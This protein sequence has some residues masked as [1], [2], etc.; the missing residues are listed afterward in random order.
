MTLRILACQIDIPA[1]TTAEERDAHLARVV[2]RVDAMLRAAPAD[3]VVLPELSSIDYSRAAFDRLEVLA[4]PLDGPSFDCWS[5]V[6]KAHGCTAVY[7][8]P[9][10]EGE[11]TYVTM[12][13]VGPDGRLVGHYDKIHLAQYGMSSEK[14][15]FTRGEGTFFFEVGGFRI[16]PI[17]CYDIRIPELSRVL[18]VEQG[19]DLILHCGAYYRDES[20]ASWHAFVTTRAIEN[21]IFFLS[22]NRAGPAFGSSCLAWPWMDDS[23]PKLDFDPIAEEFR[24]VEIDRRELTEARA[25]YSFLRDRRESYS[26][27]EHASVR[28]HVFSNRGAM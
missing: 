7:G 6:A 10:R 17:I 11:A 12:A 18:T 25:N 26:A 13:V 16:A 4:E 3:L 8:F 22:L 2:E 19:V 27:G 24:R 14:D 1:M 21:Q 20:F 15:Y 9:R 23:R 5:A 28:R